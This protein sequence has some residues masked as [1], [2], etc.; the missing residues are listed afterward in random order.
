MPK[1]AALEEEAE[2]LATLSVGQASIALRAAPAA[3]LTERE[4]LDRAL[5]LLAETNVAAAHDGL[6]RFATAQ[7]E[8]QAAEG[9]RGFD[10]AAE[11]TVIAD[12]LRRHGPFFAREG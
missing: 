1:E 12:A 11:A 3:T 8:R 9:R 6:V 10:A 4:T 5:A 7:G 2:L